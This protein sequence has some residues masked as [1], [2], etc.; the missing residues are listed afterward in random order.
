MEDVDLLDDDSSAP[1][2]LSMSEIEQEG[3]KYVA[4]YIAHKFIQDLPE[5][6]EKSSEVPFFPKSSAPW[7][8][9][10]SRGGL[11]VPS[12]SFVAQIYQMEKIFRAIHSDTISLEKEIIGQLHKVLLSKFPDLPSKILKKFSRTRTFIRIRFLN[13][14]LKMIEEEK[15]AARKRKQL[16]QFQN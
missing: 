6:G 8:T 9:S 1:C 16:S 5:L 10:L 11:V 3:F 7:I 13:T 2:N 12:E 14:R 4:G 15:N